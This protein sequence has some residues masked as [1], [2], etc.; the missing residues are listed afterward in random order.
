MPRS[1]GNGDMK[2]SC[3]IRKRAG[4]RYDLKET[5]LLC[6]FFLVGK[7][8]SI[9]IQTSNTGHD[10]RCLNTIIPC[11]LHNGFLQILTR[12]KTENIEVCRRFHNNLIDIQA[13]DVVSSKTEYKP[14][15]SQRCFM[16]QRTGS[17][18]EARSYFPT[19]ISD[20]STNP[21]PASPKKHSSLLS[22]LR[23]SSTA[24][25]HYRPA[26]VYRL[27]HQAPH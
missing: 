17:Q 11:K 2:M 10:H 19:E 24:A 15:L 7:T 13:F 23:L 3:L 8:N 5:F 9:L 6:A 18:P 16:L 14:A 22:L 26:P 21:V 1:I 4:K 20:T 12:R 25:W 27:A